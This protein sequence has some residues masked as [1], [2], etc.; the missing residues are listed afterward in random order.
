MKRT[1]REFVTRIECIGWSFDCY[2]PNGHVRLRHHN[3]QTFIIAATPSSP[4]TRLNETAAL[5]R[6]AGQRLPK[7]AHRRGRGS[8]RPGEDP[9]VV[10]SRRRHREQWEAE[11]EAREAARQREAE[12]R[13]SAA[14]SA[15]DDR[16]RRQIE[17]LMQR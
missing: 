4:R 6:L 7:V 11:A 9:Q 15:A 5:E 12:R 8:K 13:S 16:R 3:G 17:E 10:A 1:L 2:L 14:R